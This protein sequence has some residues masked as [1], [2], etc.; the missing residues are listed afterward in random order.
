MKLKTTLALAIIILF[1]FNF[2]AQNKSTKQSYD[3]VIYSGTSAG[4]TAAIQA[5]RMNNTVLIIKCCNV[6]AVYLN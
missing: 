2:N 3:I 4:I 1:T 5:A 6:K